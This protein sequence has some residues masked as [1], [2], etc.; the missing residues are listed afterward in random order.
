MVVALLWQGII[1]VENFG[2][3]YGVDG[4]VVY[5]MYIE[6]IQDRKG[7]DIC[8]DMLSRLLVDVHLDR[9]GLPPAVPA[10]PALL[11]YDLR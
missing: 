4:K 1:Q 3:H 6:A 5:G 7:D 10:A 11:R 8:I 2:M 9:S